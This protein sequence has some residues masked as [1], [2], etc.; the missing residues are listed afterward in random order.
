MRWVGDELDGPLENA[1]RWLDDNPCPDEAIGTHLRA[2]LV[3]YA[4]M[5]GASVPRM[6]ELRDGIAEHAVAI[7][8]RQTPRSTA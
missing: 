2:V 6:M 4:Q 3:A 8:R 1:R 5:P 7:D